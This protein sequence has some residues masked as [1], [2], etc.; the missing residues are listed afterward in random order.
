[1][2]SA[3]F[4]AAAIEREMSAEAIITRSF[5][6]Q[7]DPDETDTIVQNLL[8]ALSINL[9]CGNPSGSVFMQSVLVA[10]IHHVLHPG[11][12]TGQ[13]S[14]LRSR[15][16]DRQLSM[17]LE[18]ID[19][20]LPERPSLNDLAESLN[21]STGYFCRAFRASTGLPPH[22]FIIRR[23]VDRARSLIESGTLSLSDIARTVGFKDHSQMSATFR[24]VLGVSPSYFRRSRV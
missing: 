12:I 4:V 19:A 13:A 15:L 11:R 14:S 6:S 22:Q 24:K 5:A 18:L 7:R 3:G 9:S 21:V 23:R 17:V 1:M 20:Q 8:N 2:I 10:I 16:S